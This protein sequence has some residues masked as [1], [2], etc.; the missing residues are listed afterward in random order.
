VGLTIITK[1][2]G[3]FVAYFLMRNNLKSLGDGQTSDLEIASLE[4]MAKK[5]AK[6]E[7]AR[8]AL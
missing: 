3:P 5:T 2:I 7:Q 8:K 1:P 4:L 6:A